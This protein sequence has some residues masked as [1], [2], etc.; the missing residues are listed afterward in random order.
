[1]VVCDGLRLATLEYN[2]GVAN[3]FKTRLIG[4][5]VLRLRFKPSLAIT[6]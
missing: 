6:L 4:Y 3:V 2:H 1:M 5:R